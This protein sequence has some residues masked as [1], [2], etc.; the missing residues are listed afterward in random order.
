MPVP[1]K[2]PADVLARAR[3]ACAAR[4]WRESYELLREADGAGSLAPEGLELLADCAR[5]TGQLAGM[6]D[7]LERAHAAYVAAADRRGGARTALALCLANGDLANRAVA[8][9]WM[10]RAGELLAE[11]PEGAEHALYAWFESQNHSWEG[12]VEAQERSAE[13]ALELALR[14]GDRNVEALARVDL[15]H[16]AVLRAEAG[17]VREHL[18]R[19]TSLALGGEIGIL[20]SGMVFCSAIWAYRCRGEW[21]RAQEWTDS[22]TRWVNRQQ[23]DYF[24]GMCRVHRAEVLRIR[25]DLDGAEQE[26]AAATHHL[27]QALPGYAIFPWSELGEIRRRRGDLAGAREAFQRALELGWD[28]QPGLALLLLAEGDAESALRAIERVFGEAR[29]VYLKEDRASLCGARVEIALAAGRRDLAR[30]ALDELERT[31]EETGASW[32]VASACHARGRFELEAGD[33]A[34]AVGPLRRARR[35]WG[36]LEAPYE[37]ARTCALL[38]QALAEDGDPAGARI[39]LEA[40]RDVFVRIGAALAGEEVER[41][42]APLAGR[43]APPTARRSAPARAALRREGESWVLEFAGRTVRVKGTL[44]LDYL[45]ELIDRPGVERW[46][47]DLAG[48]GPDGDLGPAIDGAARAEYERRAEEIEEELA[49][50]DRRSDPRAEALLAELDAIGSALAAAVGLGGRARRAGGSIERA[51]QSVTKALRA[52]IR[53]IADQDSELGTYL[54]V[55]VRTGTA[56]RFD[57]DLREAVEWRVERGTR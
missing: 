49:R 2:S 18:E 46:S 41:A 23:V 44:G 39:E 36:E 38:G 13:R 16:V 54:E 19:A 28:P 8:N 45:A 37:L 50:I 11:L 22:S 17:A 27:P 24:P 4:E 33:V 31:M 26:C 20:A 47:V 51:R 1:A 42:L 52:A 3:R 40:A 43:P 34:A 5:W 25:G 55:T 53:R 57:P 29:P 35:A 32:D 9:V 48:A 15:A 6:L 12:D 56:C 10:R 30:G 7:P 14:A 21:Q